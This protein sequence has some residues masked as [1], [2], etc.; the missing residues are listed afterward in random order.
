MRWIGHLD[1]DCFYVSVERIKHQELL[2]YPVAVGGSPTGRGVIASASYEA[3]AFGVHS[4]M[5]AAHALRLCPNLI[6]V[7]SHFEEYEEYSDKLYSRLL[8]LAPIVERASIDEFYFDLTGCEAL[9]QHNLA[10]F[11][12]R[13]QKLVWSDLTL[14]CTVA[15]ASSKVLAKIAAGTVKPAGNICIEH[16]TEKEFLA[17]LSIDVIPGVG[18]KTSQLLRQRGF[19]IVQDLQ[20]S[21]VEQL[22]EIL[23]SNGNWI[24]TVA[25][26]HGSTHVETE[27]KRKSIGNERTFSKDISDWDALEQKM[28]PLVEKI[29]SSARSRGWRAKTVRLKLRYSDFK[30]TTHEQ[31]VAPTYDD[32]YVFHIAK[33]LLRDSYTKPLPVRLL[34]ITLTNFVDEAEPELFPSN[35]KRDRM[36]TAVDKLR[37]RFGDDVIHIG[38]V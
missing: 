20:N 26:G 10:G 38:Q 2:G 13:L 6:L 16:F 37:Q 14:P 30:T 5:P 21:T 7:R 15:L 12:K 19:R 27:H 32:P 4:A 29:C 3:R 1:L 25:L 36:L 11:I 33:R 28:F 24:R 9:Y 22:T 17:A 34:G 31:S 8:D 23:G 35:L 18:K